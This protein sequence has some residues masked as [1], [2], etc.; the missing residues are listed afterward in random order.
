MAKSPPKPG[1]HFDAEC[2]SCKAK[3]IMVVLASGKW[4][5][6]DDVVHKIVTDDG[7]IVSGRRSH[8]ATCPDADDWRKQR[9]ASGAK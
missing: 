7:A 1:Q 9:E 3:I 2:K 5:P 8:F 4:H 6:T